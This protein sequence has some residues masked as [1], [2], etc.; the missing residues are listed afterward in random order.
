MAKTSPTI[1]VLILGTGLT[2]L[3]VIRAFG[4]KGILTY[5]MSNEAD[6]ALIRFSRWFRS[7]DQ[8][9]QTTPET[10][11]TFLDSGSLEQAVLM[12]CSD[13]WVEAVARVPRR[14]STLFPSTVASPDTIALFLDKWLLAQALTKLGLPHPR[15]ILVSTQDDFIDLPDSAFTNFFLKPCNSYRFGRRFGVKAFRIRDRDDVIKR[16]DQILREG[17]SV[18]LQEYIPG[19]PTAHYFIDGFIDRAGIVRA[20][21]ARRR[22]RMYPNELGNSTCMLS[23]PITDV[24]E[25]VEILLRLLRSARY[26]GIFSAEFKYDERDGEFKLLEVNVRPWWY[27]EFAQSCNVDI[28]GLAYDDALGRALEDIGHYKIGQQCVYTHLDFWAYFA[29][30]RKPEK[31]LSIFSSW[32]KCK[33]LPFSW[34]DPAPG[35]TQLASLFW[36]S[37]I[38]KSDGERNRRTASSTGD[39]R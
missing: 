23:I 39:R 14:L 37:F 15:T 17:L 16:S 31:L 33:H 11:L 12:P 9:N 29:R 10:L 20:L 3:G 18:M 27:I 35:F 19:P 2:A 13:P 30:G 28:C 38:W 25:A 26:R 5:L 6:N 36:H 32:L 7:A 34:D 8:R 21:F 22:L 4:R 24:N 1:P